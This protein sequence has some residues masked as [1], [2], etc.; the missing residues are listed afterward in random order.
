[1]NKEN[2]TNTLQN[3]ANILYNFLKT[4][5]SINVEDYSS[6]ADIYFEV[7]DLMVI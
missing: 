6:I 7:I 5:K 2:M 4:N 1:M 3:T